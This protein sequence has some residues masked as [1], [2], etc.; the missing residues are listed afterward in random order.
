MSNL[1]LP[2]ET[3]YFQNTYTGSETAEELI[4]APTNSTQRIVI[5]QAIFST[6]GATLNIALNHGAVVLLPTQFM[7]SRNTWNSGS[8]FN[9]Q[10][11]PGANI[12]MDTTFNIGPGSGYTVW[13]AYHIQ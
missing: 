12:N 2:Y 1:N 7:E 6:D 4:P 5:E 10:A 9:L 8:D 13:I 3:K 11:T